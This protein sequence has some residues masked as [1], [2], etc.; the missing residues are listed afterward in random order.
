[1]TIRERQKWFLREWR[2]HRGL[3]IEK[4]A[5]RLDV[6]KGYVS[7]MERG[8]KRYNQDQLEALAD[9]LECEPA[10]L[11]MRDPSDTEAVW[12]VWECVPAAKREDALRVLKAFSEPNAPASR[13]RVKKAS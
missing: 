12:S 5:E 9:A 11:L 1:M 3:T 13:G 6:S 7:D 8:K 2:K 10:D 4:L